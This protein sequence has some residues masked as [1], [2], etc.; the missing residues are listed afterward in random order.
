[1]PLLI[2]AHYLPN[3]QYLTKFLLFERVIIDD[4]ENFGKQSYRNRCYLTGANGLIS[5]I[6]P[7]HNSKSG[8]PINDIKIDNATRWQHVHW[9][10]ICSAY[11]KT[12]F[13]EHYAHG[14]EPFYSNNE[15]YL[16]PFNLRLTRL[17]MG[18]L[19]IAPDRLVLKSAANETVTVDMHNQIH[20]KEKYNKEDQYFN[21]QAYS[22]A[23]MDRYGFV[24][25]LSILDLIFN[26]GPAAINILQRSIR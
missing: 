23:F 26:E 20:P 2:E 24:A 22:Q 17:I 3:I 12:P 15:E 11:G 14:L 18:W 16:L 1:M 10:S 5:L 8:L 13:F 21:M 6:I 25:N 7:V 4:T 9:Q 19:K